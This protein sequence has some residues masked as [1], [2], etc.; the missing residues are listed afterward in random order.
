MEKKKKNHWCPNNGNEI[1][2]YGYIETRFE[3][4]F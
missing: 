1:G 3:F 2:K 4:K